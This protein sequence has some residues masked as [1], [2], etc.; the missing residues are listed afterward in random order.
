MDGKGPASS[1]EAWYAINGMFAS[2]FRSKVQ[3]LRTKLQETK[4][5]Q[6]SVGIILPLVQLFELVIVIKLDIM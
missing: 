1:T 3:H 4:K 6:M 2:A 5:L